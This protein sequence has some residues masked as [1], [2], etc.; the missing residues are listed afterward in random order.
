MRYEQSVTSMTVLAT[1]SGPGR[2]SIPRVSLSVILNAR[3]VFGPVTTGLTTIFYMPLPPVRAA[4]SDPVSFVFYSVGTNLLA[5]STAAPPF[6]GNFSQRI[7]G[8]MPPV[9]DGPRES[10]SIVDSASLI[11]E[12]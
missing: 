8:V 10:L 4:R 3:A 9:F 7:P 1:R 5:F 2:V 6:L 11:E 12:P